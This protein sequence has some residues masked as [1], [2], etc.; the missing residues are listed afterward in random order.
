[1]AK[2]IERKFMVVS[3]AWR[4]TAETSRTLVQAYLA[5]DGETSVR[6]RILDG[7]E[8]WLTVKLG[9]SEM[10]RDEFEYPVPLDDARD[11]VEASRGRVIEKTRHIIKSDAHVWEV[12]VFEGALAGLVMAEVEMGAEDEAPALPAWLGREVTGDP[13]W[14]NAVLATQGWPEG[15]HL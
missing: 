5:I 10:T 8:A 3:D 14:T 4:D 9:V 15:I 13:A 7:D 6:V 12:D 1:M 2:E 11:M